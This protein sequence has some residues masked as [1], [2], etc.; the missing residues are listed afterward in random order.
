MLTIL[1]SSTLNRVSLFFFILPESSNTFENKYD[2]RRTAG[3]R[4]SIPLP[5]P[6]P[7][8]LIHPTHPGAAISKTECSFEQRRHGMS[9]LEEQ[10]L[11]WR[12]CAFDELSLD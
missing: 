8:P 1:N 4:H 3:S 12:L 6:R 7:L 10:A 11:R 5:I 2:Q 9:A